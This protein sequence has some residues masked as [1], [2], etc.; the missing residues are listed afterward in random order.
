MAK[1][2][3]LFA[4]VR[5]QYLLTNK[6]GRWFVEEILRLSPPLADD[7]AARRLARD[8]YGSPLSAGDVEQVAR[9][10][11]A[12]E[13]QTAD[14][15]I[16]PCSGGPRAKKEHAVVA[17][18]HFRPDEGYSR[19]R[20]LHA[21]TIVPDFD[22]EPCSRPEKLGCSIQDATDEFQPIRAAGECDPR[23]AVVLGR[24]PAHGGRAT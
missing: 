3:R 13:K 10:R 2:V 21:A 19:K 7:C 9:R 15:L 16:I 22:N 20:P 12:L 23:L 1:D 14:A 24:E 17:R 8:Q 5:D 4:G 11:R 6:P 18:A